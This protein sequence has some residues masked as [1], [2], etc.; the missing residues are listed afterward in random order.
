[1]QDNAAHLGVL[2][3]IHT[4]KNGTYWE[5]RKNAGQ[6]R[7][8][9]RDTSRNVK[10]LVGNRWWYTWISRMQIVPIWTKIERDNSTL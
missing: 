5:K 9:K 3:D 7:T 10:P 2:Q 4:L 8:L 6:S 1:M